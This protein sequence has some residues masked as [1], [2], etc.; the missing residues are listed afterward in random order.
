MPERDVYT[1]WLE[2]DILIDCSYLALHIRQIDALRGE[3][4]SLDVFITYGQASP[5]KRANR[6]RL[7]AKFIIN[8]LPLDCLTNPGA[9]GEKRRNNLMK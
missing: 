8:I 5:M 6:S 1:H 3:K 9:A 2:S 4:L 7:A